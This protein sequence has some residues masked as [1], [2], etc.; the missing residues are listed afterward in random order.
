M[1]YF[2]LLLLIFLLNSV[3]SDNNYGRWMEDNK[4]FIANKTLYNIV[5]PGTHDTGISV[6]IN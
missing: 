6:K 2:P 5:L 4:E 1:K 3:K